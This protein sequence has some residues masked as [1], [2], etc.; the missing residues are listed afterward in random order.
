[1]LDFSVTFIITIINIAALFFILRAL[2]FKPVT[3]F[4][5]ER[6]K[7][8]QDSIDQ[9]NN[10]KAE[11]EKYLS[12][13]EIRLEKIEAEA[14]EILRAAREKAAEE[15]KRIIAEGRLQAADI[16][17]KTHKQLEAERRAILANFNAEAALLVMAASSKLACKEISDS[18]NQRYAN[19]LLDE[20]A[21]Q[22]DARQCTV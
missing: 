8:I 20:L 3:K 16:I 4:M 15:S 14:A 9:A 18:E 7:R 13:C 11:G 19:M 1:M 22:K 12:Q 6:A 10:D 21:S 5:E 2:L 17:S